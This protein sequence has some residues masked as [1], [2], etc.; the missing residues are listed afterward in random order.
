MG[1]TEI[2]HALAQ[3]TMGNPNR[4]TKIKCEHFQESHTLSNLIGSPKGYIGSNEESILGKNIYQHIK[5]A[6]KEKEAS[7]IIA[8]YPHFNIILLDEIEKA[9]PAIH[10]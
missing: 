4:I 6:R 9:H 5:E 1:K 7:N 10:Q 3:V 2:A 8:R